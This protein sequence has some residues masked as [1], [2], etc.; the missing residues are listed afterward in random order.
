MSL[1]KVKEY[2]ETVGLGQRIHELSQTT[3]TVEDAAMAIGCEPERIAKTMSFLLDGEPILIVTAG[4]AKI[5]NRKYKDYFHKK[6]KMITAELVEQSIGHAP[7][8]VCPFAINPNV[9]VYL[10]ISLKRFET[11]YPAAGSS[12]SAVELSIEELV[13]HSGSS[14]WIDVCNHWS[15]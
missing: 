6:A 12:N 15:A 10:D 7:G 14:G 1:E 9:K 3:A 5:D 11:V 2:F 8:G 4:D 13:S